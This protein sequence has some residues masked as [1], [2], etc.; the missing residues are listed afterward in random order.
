MDAREVVAIAT[1]G[2]CKLWGPRGNYLIKGL[3][4][5]RNTEVCMRGPQL[6]ASS[7]NKQV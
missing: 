5:H 3:L 2:R 4:R 7:D 6:A 1:Y